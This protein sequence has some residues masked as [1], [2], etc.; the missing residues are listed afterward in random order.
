MDK[1]TFFMALT[2][3]FGVCLLV[4][5]LL[6]FIETRDNMR[7]RKLLDQKVRDLGRFDRPGS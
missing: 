5:S 2:I 3:L 7:L 1:A 4:I 6:Y